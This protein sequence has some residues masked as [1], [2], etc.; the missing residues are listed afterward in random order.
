MVIKERSVG[1]LYIDGREALDTLDKC[2]VVPCDIEKDEKIMNVM[3]AF[4]EFSVSFCGS[5]KYKR[6]D[7]LSFMYNMKITNNYL[8]LHGGIMTREVAGRK[9]VR[10][11]R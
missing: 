8:K 6:N 3:N 5:I 2:E 9:G 1:K 11:I 10:K 4:K 7:A